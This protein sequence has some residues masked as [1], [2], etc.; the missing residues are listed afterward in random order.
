MFNGKLQMIGS[1]VD[2]VVGISESVS[3][4]DVVGSS[5][6]QSYCS[7]S[8]KLLMGLLGSG[9]LVFSTSDLLGGFGIFE[10]GSKIREPAL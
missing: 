1:D 10:A 4:E 9:V 8:E 5:E 7:F 2:Q 3:E 6:Y